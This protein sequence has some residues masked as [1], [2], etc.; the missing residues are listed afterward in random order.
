MKTTFKLFTLLL[1]IF[2]FLACSDDD[3]DAVSEFTVSTISPNP[4]L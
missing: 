4:G 1:V 2:S 3:G